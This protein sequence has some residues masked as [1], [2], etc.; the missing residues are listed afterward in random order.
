MRRSIAQYVAAPWCALAILL[1][2]CTGDGAATD[3]DRHVE[4]PAPKP[5]NSGITEEYFSFSMPDRYLAGDAFSV[6]DFRFVYVHPENAVNLADVTADELREN[7]ITF[8]IGIFIVDEDLH[9]L[10][11]IG[12][13]RSDGDELP[14]FPD[15]GTFALEV[16]GI[17]GG[18]EFCE[19]RTVTIAKELGTPIAG[20]ELQVFLDVL[21]IDMQ[22]FD[23]L[24][25]GVSSDSR[26]TLT[27]QCIKLL[28][29]V[30]FGTLTGRDVEWNSSHTGKIYDHYFDYSCREEVCENMAFVRT[31]YYSY[32]NGNEGLHEPADLSDFAKAMKA[33]QNGWIQI[34]R[35]EDIMYGFDD[36]LPC[37][38]VSGNI[39]CSGEFKNYDLQIENCGSTVF[40]FGDDCRFCLTFDNSD[41]YW[42][43][44]EEELFDLFNRLFP[45]DN[46]IDA[47]EII[48][49][50][51][52]EIP[53]YESLPLFHYSVRQG[54]SPCGHWVAALY[55]TYIKNKMREKIKFTM[56]YSRY[57]FTGFNELHSGTLFKGNELRTDVRLPRIPVDILALG[58]S[59]L[60]V[61]DCIITGDLTEETVF[62]FVN[63]KNVVFEGDV[64]GISSFVMYETTVHGSGVVWFQN[65]P[66]NCYGFSGDCVKFSGSVESLPVRL[67]DQAVK[68]IDLT[69]WDIDDIIT[70][71]DNTEKFDGM[72]TVT[73][74][75]SSDKDY[76]EHFI[77]EHNDTFSYYFGGHRLL[78]S[79]YP[80]GAFDV[81]INGK[82]DGFGSWLGSLPEDECRDNW[83]PVENS[84][85]SWW[86]ITE[87]NVE[88]IFTAY[89]TGEKNFDG[90]EIN[91]SHTLR[92]QIPHERLL[93]EWEHYGTYEVFKRGVDKKEFYRDMVELYERE[94]KYEALM[95]SEY[96]SHRCAYEEAKRRAGL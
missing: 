64:S 67:G 54:Q 45:Q 42:N 44:D 48:L 27:S 88:A 6:S 78:H 4:T 11:S 92:Y 86:P 12:S 46:R 5:D 2:A 33:L 96:L 82:Y 63:L 29:D 22:E 40:V 75:K 94:S 20:N 39:L 32:R 8:Q 17:V 70:I 93:E 83:T 77:Q 80:S 14:V 35:D 87:K 24:A 31:Y 41:Y 76:A 73:Y 49:A 74:L 62:K 37:Y 53:S 26:V 81:Y 60:Y 50:T 3:D 91:P 89:E 66:I 65:N 84:N 30:Y 10:A 56:S 68:A 85:S 43:I 28:G 9:R 79:F 1:A 69:D 90:Y 13:I 51:E 21:G 58:T 16:S 59:S 7:G 72:G 95:S 38:A 55:K 19:Y 15:A 36:V 25:S 61:A 47:A 71:Y 18:V 23:R 57:S 34:E 52:T